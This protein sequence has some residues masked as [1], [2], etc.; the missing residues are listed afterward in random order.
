MASDLHMPE[1]I[2]DEILVKLP[3]KSL[4]RF[5]C[6]SKSWCSIITSHGFILNHLRN[7]EKEENGTSI[8]KAYSASR[9]YFIML[10]A[11]WNPATREIRALSVPHLS[12][13]YRSFIK[14][15]KHVFGFGFDPVTNDHKV[16]SIEIVWMESETRDIIHFPSP[17]ACHRKRVSIYSMRDD[18]W[19]EF[20]GDFP[21]CYVRYSWAKA[22]YVEGSFYP[23]IDGVYYW[24]AKDDNDRPVFLSFHMSD[25]VFQ[26][27]PEKGG[28]PDQGMYL[29]PWGG[30]ISDWDDLVGSRFGVYNNSLAWIESYPCG[31]DVPN[32]FNIWVLKEGA[33]TKKFLGPF[34]GAT[35]P[36]GFWKT[37]EL[38]ILDAEQSLFVANPNT[39]EMKDL[40]T[41]AR[42]AFV[43]HESLIS[44]KRRG[45]ELDNSTAKFIDAWY[46]ER[47][48][49]DSSSDE[50]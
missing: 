17:M 38:L 24:C 11:L 40:G 27:I 2:I 33:W 28:R 31:C 29:G 6:V 45:E 44:V 50:E 30:L 25:E 26:V 4:L 19:R 20:T 1:E 13:T 46:P 37:G 41:V 8:V 43:Y 32:V 10:R 7:S 14:A 34:A 35:L 5:K 3:V 18:S 23:Y 49:D 15:H 16:V 36:L 9:T 47:W 39:L 22:P 48:D 42:E 21:K 12:I